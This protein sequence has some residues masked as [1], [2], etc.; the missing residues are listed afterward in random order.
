VLRATDGDA[1]GLQLT[2][3]SNESLT[4]TVRYGQ[5]MAD[6]LESYG[7]TLLGATGLIARRETELSDNLA[8][9]ETNLEDIE[10]KA[11]ALTERYNIRFGR[12]EA[13][14]TSMNKTGEYMQ[15]LMD[16]WNA[17]R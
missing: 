8:G 9:F 13:V 6:Q 7:E 12:M 10:T 14:I 5:S 11:A 1:Y 2:L 3:G 16:A 15:S 4:T 17:D